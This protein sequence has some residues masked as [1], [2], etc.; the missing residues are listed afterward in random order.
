M[1]GE[2][3]MHHERHGYKIKVGIGQDSHKFDFEDKQRKLI[4]GG[5]TFE[6]INPLM[7]NSDADVVLHSIANAI[8]SV[9]GVN[10]LGEIAD[11]M[12]LVDKIANSSAYVKEALKYMNESEILHVSISIECLRPAISSRILEMKKNIA[13]LLNMQ[14]TDVGITATTGEGL[15]QFGQGKGIQSFACITVKQN[16]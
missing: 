5:V 9:T 1:K 6:N 2:E 15:T 4:L 3:P 10:I 13:R 11:K 7:G 16:C 8:S 12:C 14:E